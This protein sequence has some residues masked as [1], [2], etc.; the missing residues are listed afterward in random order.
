M[1]YQPKVKEKN[2]LLLSTVSP[3]IMG[4]TKDDSVKKPAIYKLYDFTKGGT[5]IIDQ[6]V[7]F[8]TVHT[9]SRRWT[10]NALAYILDTARENSQTIY[11]IANNLDPRK[12]SALTFGWNL[13]KALCCPQIERRKVEGSF[14]SRSTIAKTDLILGQAREEEE[15][16]LPE[17]PENRK[18]NRCHACLEVAYGPGY[19]RNRPKVSKVSSQCEVCHK[20]V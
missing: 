6:R 12:S 10:V 19:S 2:V 20:H 3:I 7:H 17:A 15:N 1:W 4:V 18:R 13:V 14:L 9:K 11:S 8:Y 16:A 5:D